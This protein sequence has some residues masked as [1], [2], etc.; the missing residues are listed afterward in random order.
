M[1]PPFKSTE[2]FLDLVINDPRV[3]EQ[4]LTSLTKEKYYISKF[5]N[6][7]YIDADEITRIERTMLLKFITEDIENEDEKIKQLRD[8]AK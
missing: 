1:M 4:I 3:R 8:R 2:H 5:L 6:T 7:S